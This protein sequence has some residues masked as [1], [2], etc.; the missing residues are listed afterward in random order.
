M[1]TN[2]CCL[3][4]RTTL[5]ISEAYKFVESHFSDLSMNSV[6][7]RGIMSKIF[8]RESICILCVNVLANPCLFAPRIWDVGNMCAYCGVTIIDGPRG[9][10]T[11]TSCS[12]C[13]RKLRKKKVQAIEFHGIFC[14]KQR[15]FISPDLIRFSDQKKCKVCKNNAEV[16]TL[17]ES[18]ERHAFY[19]RRH[20]P[21][22][23]QKED[24]ETDEE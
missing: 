13:N 6:I 11:K 14:T 5:S 19:C 15:H 7:F 16:A 23:R 22:L 17:G 21:S 9:F 20:F 12:S 4:G 3:C 1:P 10:N 24:S 8:R 2:E 18:S